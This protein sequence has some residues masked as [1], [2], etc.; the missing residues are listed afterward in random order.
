M[1]D[2]R[3]LSIPRNKDRKIEAIKEAIDGFSQEKIFFRRLKII[4]IKGRWQTGKIK[5]IADKALR[6]IVE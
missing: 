4:K 2:E 5:Q 6:L 3:D 1:L